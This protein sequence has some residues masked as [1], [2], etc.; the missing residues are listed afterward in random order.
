[1]HTLLF[2]A[3][4]LTTTLAGAYFMGS[5]SIWD[6]LHYSLPFLGI[7][8]IHEF[9]HYFAAR[10]YKISASLPYYIPLWLGGVLT[11]G[12]AGA[13]IRLR[14]RVK[15][16]TQYFDIGIAGPLAGF[17]AALCVLYYGFTHL[18]PPEHIFTI[19]P[20][21][22][23]HGLE[24]AKYVYNNQKDVFYLG[25]NLLLFFFEKYVAPDPSLVPNQYELMHYPYLFSGYLALFFTA[26]NL[27]PIGQLDGG[28]VIYGL[29]G[30]KN[31][32]FISKVLFSVLLFYAGLGIITP[33]RDFD[34][35]IQ[36]TPLY[37]FFLYIV[38]RGFGPSPLSR[39]FWA[40]IFLASQYFTSLIFSKV[41]G[42]NGWLLFVFLLGAMLGI[43]H[44]KAEEDLPL[45]Q[46]RKILG[47]VALVIF[48]LCFTPAPFV[49]E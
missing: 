39:L 14:G 26:L 12:T 7:L 33:Y 20:E 37:L 1:M 44:P 22:K 21:Y 24:Y 18:P 31:H 46:G 25:K 11:I 28:H 32:T 45:T 41:Q 30:S 49:F 6:G 38:L 10:R 3:T 13:V 17:L 27:I 16:K 5:S 36:Y 19:H 15:S 9:G 23:K 8:T 48:V 29:A 40:M 34:F 4:L 47:W 2:V 35:L 43:S 42:Y